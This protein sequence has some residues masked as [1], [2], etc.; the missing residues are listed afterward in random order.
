[1]LHSGLGPG[2]GSQVKLSPLNPH[3]LGFC[4]NKEALTL[5]TQEESRMGAHLSAGKL[6]ETT[7]TQTTLKYLGE[8]EPTVYYGKHTLAS[9]G[10]LDKPRLTVLCAL[11]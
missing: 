6:F 5:Q 10:Q 8:R 1:M 9:S 2:T 3:R 4:N 7:L 11:S